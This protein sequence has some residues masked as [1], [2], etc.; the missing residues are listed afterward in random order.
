MAKPTPAPDV[1]SLVLTVRGQRVMIDADLAIIYAVPLNRFNE[2]V[3]R[4]EDRFPI[5]FRFLL[6]REEVTNLKSQFAISSLEDSDRQ[7][8]SSAKHGGR[9]KLPWAFTEHGCLMAATVLN[10]PRAVQMSLFIVRAFVQMR[11]ALAANATIL[12]RLAEI[13]RT[14]LEHDDALRAIWHE[15]QPLLL[16]PPNRQNAGSDSPLSYSSLPP[17]PLASGFVR[18]CLPPGWPLF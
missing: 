9:R 14:L 1:Q 15:L 12:K 17:C 13:D 2:A 16:P 6:T 8:V 4:N 11:E 10:S 5:D 3:K 7:A 18:R